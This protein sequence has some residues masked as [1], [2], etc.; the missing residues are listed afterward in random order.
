MVHYVCLC[1]SEE[2]IKQ[3]LA[4]RKDHFMNPKLLDSQF[5]IL[6]PPDEAIRV[7]VNGTPH[8][9]AIE[10]RRKLGL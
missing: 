3:R 10:I 9:I 7:D 6:E 8:A 1:G 2:L 5:E 4:A